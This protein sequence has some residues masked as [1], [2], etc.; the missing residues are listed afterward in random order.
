MCK[1]KEVIW[2]EVKQVD[3]HLLEKVRVFSH[4]SL[5]HSFGAQVVVELC[6]HP[7]ELTHD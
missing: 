1:I 5:Q 2:Q 3:K 7:I 6:V 4:N